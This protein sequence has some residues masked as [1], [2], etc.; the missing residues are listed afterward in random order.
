MVA[1]LGA[2]AAGQQPAPTFEVASIKVAR[3]DHDSGRRLFVAL[4]ADRDRAAG[5][6]RRTQ[7]GNDAEAAYGGFSLPGQIVGARRLGEQHAIRGSM[8]VPRASAAAAMNAMVQQML[9]ERF[10]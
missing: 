4:G 1:L 3:S 9:A 6:S 5:G 8:R 2:T 10:K 7:R